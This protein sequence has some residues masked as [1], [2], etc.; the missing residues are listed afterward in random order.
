MMTFFKR[1]SKLCLTLG[2]LWVAGNSRA[3]DFVVTSPGFYFSFNGTNAANSFPTLRLVRGRTYTFSLNTTPGFHPFALGTSVFGAA[4]AGVSGNNNNSS[5]TITF[6]VPANAPNCVYYC[7]VHGG[8]MTGNILME[9]PPMPPSIRIVGL[10]V[11]K[12]L[13][14]TS[15]MAS[16]NGLTIVP[17]FNTNLAS[18]NWFALTVQSNRFANGTNE[19]FCGRPPG[20]AVLIR[21]RAQQN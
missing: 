8:T 19:A 21:V 5:G 2:V 7:G 3:A 16:T 10:N 15:T 20:N 17:E 6:A 18:G 4:P 13:T 11:S 12:N 9:D 14:V 1:V